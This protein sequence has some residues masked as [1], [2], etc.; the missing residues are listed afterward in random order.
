[1]TKRAAFLFNFLSA[2][3]L[4]H[5]AQADELPVIGQT[6]VTTPTRSEEQ[7]DLGLEMLWLPVE[8]RLSLTDYVGRNLPG[9]TLEAEGRLLLRGARAQDTAFELDGL[10]VKGL[11]L[12]LGMV[13]RFDLA[14]SGFGAGAGLEYRY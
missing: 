4:A 9:A 12:P 13:E 8:S 5:G 14:T 10:R 3:L 11:S 6:A 2:V 1:M 7:R